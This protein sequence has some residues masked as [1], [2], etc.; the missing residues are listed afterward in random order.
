MSLEI[1]RMTEN[2]VKEYALGWSFNEGWNPGLND[3][4]SFFAADPQGYFIGFLNGEP[5]GCMSA[6]AYDDNYGFLGFYIVRE[7]YRG[8]GYGIKIWN[9]AISYLGDR[10]IGLD[11]V[12]SQQSNYMKSGF[13]S[14]YTTCRYTWKN[15]KIELKEDSQ[16]VTLVSFDD[17]SLDEFIEYDGNMFPAPRKNFLIK[18]CSNPEGMCRVAT[19]NNVIV[20]YIVAR[21]TNNGYKI[22]PL[23]SDNRDIAILLIQAIS[24]ILPEQTTL[25]LDIPDYNN[26][27]K[28]FIQEYELQPVFQTARMYK[29]GTP[30]INYPQNV[31]GVS[32]LEL[33]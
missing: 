28:D 7:E 14:D 2:E 29:N 3:A 8:K 10:I 11:G 4:E 5:I 32:S 24:S 9:E 18:W 6:V 22:G 15:R 26:E 1:R 13:H 23:F 17:V 21:K 25:F 19:K 20:G 31:F 27:L 33:G 12:V 30:K 16:N